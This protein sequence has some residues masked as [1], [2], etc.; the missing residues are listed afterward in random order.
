MMPPSTEY[1]LTTVDNP[2]DPFIEFDE[3]YAF[4]TRE[5]YYTLAFLARIVRS[6]PDISD[7]DQKLAIQDAIEEIVKENVSGIYRKV[8]RQ[9]NYD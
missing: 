8:A 6:S 7:V 4:D 1:M 2:Y 9:V 5:R 3:W